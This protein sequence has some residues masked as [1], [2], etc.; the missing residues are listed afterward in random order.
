MC[1]RGPGSRVTI[2]QHCEEKKQMRSNSSRPFAAA[3]GATVLATALAPATSA[4]ENPFAL[5]ELRAGYQLAQEGSTPA[6]G[7]CGEGKCGGEK[8]GEGKCGAGKSS[9]EGKC[10]AAK[11]SSEGKCGTGKAAEGKC[12][13]E[14]QCGGAPAGDG[15]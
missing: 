3:L 15:T 11:S 1:R 4:E 5:N 14:G 12:C 10:G 2:Q 8:P 9:S 6:E 7:K 13:A